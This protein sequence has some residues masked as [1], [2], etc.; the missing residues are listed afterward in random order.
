MRN[1]NKNPQ[2]AIEQFPLMTSV[3]LISGIGEKYQARP[4]ITIPS[5]MIFAKLLP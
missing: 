3:F 5:G 4:S 2:F 1:E